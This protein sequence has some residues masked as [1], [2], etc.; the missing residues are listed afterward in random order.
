MSDPGRHCLLRTVCPNTTNIYLASYLDLGRTI[1]IEARSFVITDL[2]NAENVLAP[3]AN[4]KSRELSAH[5]D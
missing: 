2:T 4:N 5:S 3:Y 1:P